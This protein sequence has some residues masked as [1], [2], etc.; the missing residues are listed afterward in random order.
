MFKIILTGVWVA[1]VALGTVYAS[2]ELSKPGD[3][4]AE[5]AAKK[6]VQELVRGELTTYPVI[7][8]GR[9]EGY[10]LAKLSYIA[11]KTKVA[12]ITLP[13]GPL[14][15][16][17]LYSALVGEKVIRIGY[18]RNLDVKVFRE[19]VKEAVNKR[20]GDEVVFDVI[21]EQIDYMSKEALQG[22]DNAHGK[23]LEKIV[24]EKL[25]EGYEDKEASSGH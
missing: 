18:T 21:I 23:G 4:N 10:F 11:D 1:A 3:P 25:P 19:R 20:L 14:I 8:D 17:E 9:V 6:A 13:I 5:E 16:D 24:A 12:A 7:A 2:I 22:K 15:T